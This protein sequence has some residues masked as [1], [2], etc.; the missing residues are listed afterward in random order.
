MGNDTLKLTAAQRQQF[1]EDGFF[2]V[3]D[4]LAADE[5]AALLA[6]VDALYDRYAAERE[7]GP[8]EALQIRRSNCSCWA[9]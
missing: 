5:V 1:D 2:L 9:S 3:E 4:A 6:V 7:L 8:H